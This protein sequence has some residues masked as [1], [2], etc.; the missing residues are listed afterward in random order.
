M[1]KGKGKGKGKE[2]EEDNDARS[3][4]QE[5]EMGAGIDDWIRDLE[6]QLNTDSPKHKEREGSSGSTK[7]KST[8]MSQEQ[9]DLVYQLCRERIAFQSIVTIMGV[10]NGDV[11]L[12]DLKRIIVEAE[13]SFDEERRMQG[14]CIFKESPSRTRN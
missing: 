13:A 2:E 3:G 5:S 7:A 6:R 12:S 8:A 1:D 11:S 10:R 14:E 4:Q 9:I